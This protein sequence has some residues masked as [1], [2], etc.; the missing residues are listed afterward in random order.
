MDRRLFEDQ[1]LNVWQKRDGVWYPTWNHYYDFS[2][3]HLCAKCYREGV[4]IIDDVFCRGMPG[5][6]QLKY[7]NNLEDPR[8]ATGEA[9]FTTSSFSVVTYEY[10]D[11][12]FG[13]HERLTFFPFY[14]YERTVTY[15]YTQCDYKNITYEDVT[16]RSEGRFPID[17]GMGRFRF[18]DLGGELYA[19]ERLF[20]SE[21][22]NWFFST[23]KKWCMLYAFGFSLVRYATNE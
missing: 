12:T 14:N 8:G 21:V 6:P 17:I 18:M 7:Q 3:E 11:G 13:A 2:D 19:P 9:R 4:G 15:P 22:R 5:S 23:L 20:H 1:V 10:E 16:L